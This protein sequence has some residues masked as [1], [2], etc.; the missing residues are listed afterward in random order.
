[1]NDSGPTTP[2]ADRTPL[3]G[4]LAE[5]GTGRRGVERLA[6][7]VERLRRELDAHE[8]AAATRGLLD[9]AKGILVERGVDGPA[10]A[11]RHLEEL[12]ARAGVP[13]AELA[14][15]II[16]EAAHDTLARAVPAPQEGAGRTEPPTSVRL[17]MAEAGALSGTDAQAVAQ[18]LLVHALEPL[19]ATA[20]AVW[21]AD[22]DGSLTLAGS[23][24]FPAAEAVRWRYVPPR[25]GTLAQQTLISGRTL[26]HGAL[27]SSAVSIGLSGVGD[28][29]RAL[30]P[31]RR[32][33]RAVGVL[34]VCWP[35]P[36]APLSRAVHRQLTGL[37]ELCAHT[38]EGIGSAAS[39]EPVRADGAAPLDALAE[40]L[41]D[42][43][44]VLRP[45]LDDQGRVG[46]FRITY[47]NQHCTDFA[48]R[49]R[50]DITGR[51]LLEAYPLA[52]AEG[53][54]YERALRVHTT[55]EPF[56]TERMVLPA[57]AESTVPLVTAALGIGRYGDA[58]LV[59]W[60]TH[61]DATRLAALVEHTQ[62]L[63]RIGGFEET[64]AIGEVIWNSQ[65]F[66]LYG[67]P[68][69]S[70]P[71][72]LERLR[73]HAHPDDADVIGRF[74]REV[75]H[76]R[77]PASTAFR[78]LRPDGVVRYIRAVAEPAPGWEGGPMTVQGAYQ[79]V[80]SQHWTEVALAATRDRLADSEQRADERDLLALQLQRAIMPPAPAP[81]DVSGLQVAVRYRP[82]EK[83][84]LVGG[85]WY[86]A[87]VLPDQQVLLVVGDIAG[88]GIDAA[89][90][91]VVL[92]N[93]LRGLAVTGAGPGRLLGWL[94][95][96]AHRLT[97]HVTATVICGLYDP[98]TR[99]VR[100]ARAGHPP[101]VLVRGARS[102]VLPLPSGILL[103]AVAQ[104]RYAEETV[105]LEPGDTLLLYTDGL[106]ER[107]DRTV[108]QS[109][110]QLLR[111]AGPP[112][113]DL[114]E[115]LDRL[116]THSNSD[117]DDDT[118]VIGFRPR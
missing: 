45:L 93:A 95:T 51:S 18:S 27:P 42:C 80:S 23:A 22:Q 82:A 114:E 106:L 5:T 44:L 12:A 4:P 68:P 3:R 62:R 100:W 56:R 108:N 2:D 99:V 96:V 70:A 63:G 67:L 25:V 86:D 40:G 89:T 53:G 94:N 101:P 60:R 46:D 72:P 104:A 48:G 97:E 111:D 116:L 10:G 47:I 50:A 59:S 8:N 57:A 107:R 85:D 115:D 83:G 34:E 73:H 52:A 75:L 103:G 30:I 71:I 11:A 29:A 39:A 14:A 77:R 41:L 24:G 113:G 20:V 19:G 55:G 1:M 58:L 54:L 78:L 7:V 32:T 81:I 109:L 64:P 26:W 91:M 98:A 61:N 90:G 16:N 79:D 43:A 28:G 15:D 13:A 9:V 84:H 105:V 49:P 65:L 69:D 76:R 33:S 74:L 36:G 118:C 37:A 102:T 87:V 117:T 31:A 35:E 6:A 110:E 17:R 38:L 112:T 66:D 21:Q 92:R 88:H